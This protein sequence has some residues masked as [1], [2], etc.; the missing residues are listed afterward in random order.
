MAA[1]FSRK[2]LG[3]CAAIY[4]ALCLWLTAPAYAL[5]PGDVAFTL[6]TG[7][8]GTGNQDFIVDSNNCGAEG[9]NAA[10]V[11]GRVTNTSGGLLSNLTATMSGFDVANGFG[12]EGGQTATQFIGSLNA[13]ESKNVY[14]YNKYACTEPVTDT[15]DITITDGGAP[16]I[17]NVDVTTRSSI[18]ANAGGRVTSSLLGPGAIVGQTIDMSAVYEFGNVGNGDEF[19][20]QPTGTATFDAACFQ[21]VGATI[22]ASSVNAIPPGTTD[23]LYFVASGNQG[24]SGKPVTVEYDF[25]YLCDGIST[26]ASPYA[27][28]TSGASNLKYTGNFDAQVPISFPPATNPYAV[29]KSASPTSFASGTPSPVV[30]YT[31]TVTNPSAFDGLVDSVTDVLPAGALFKGIQPGSDATAANSSAVPAINDTGTVQFVGKPQTSYA[32]GAGASISVIYSVELPGADGSYVNSATVQAGSSSSGPATIT[33]NVGTGVDGSVTITPSIAP[34]DDLTITVTDA[35]LDVAPGVQDTVVVT[36]VNDASGESEQVTLTETG[37]STG[38]FTDTLSTAQGGSPGPD[39]DGVLVVDA[40]DTATVTYVD[41][42][43][44]GGGST[45]RTASSTVDIDSDGD[46]VPD[47]TDVDDDND[48]IPDATE[49][50]ADGDGDGLA[51]ALDID[52]DG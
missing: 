24:G 40:G 30:T 43:D 10:Y 8:A 1:G 29:A 32:I 41:L 28:Q 36:V 9:P 26:S 42:F 50:G 12:L 52:S 15:L 7:D 2:A 3:Q 27:A 48:G 49:A 6:A 38:I 25:L 19:Y 21:L 23:Q 20:L 47:A 46:G 51:D 31:V 37:V 14:W 17:A 22:S 35:D 34:G 5:A 33:V 44:S 11:G 13:G 18:S 39:D 4:A 45:N 16:V